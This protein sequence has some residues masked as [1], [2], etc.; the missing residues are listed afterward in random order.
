ME[1]LMR[2]SWQ[3]E[4][5]R[6]RSSLAFRGVSDA[7]HDLKTSLMRLGAPYP[8]LE[9]HLI[10]NFQKYGTLGDVGLDYSEWKWL[11]IGQHHRLPTRLLD[12]TY[13]PLVALHFA[14]ADRAKCER[15]G[16]VWCVDYVRSHKHIPALLRDA[17]EEVGAYTFTVGMLEDLV[18]S[19][20]RFDALSGEPFAIFFEPPSVDARIINQYAMFSVLSSPSETLDGWLAQ[21]PELYRRV[22]IPAR[23]K[24][25]VRDK[26]DQANV[27]ERVLFPGLDGL[28]AWLQRHYGPPYT[29]SAADEEPNE[30]TPPLRG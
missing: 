17:L 23:I 21:R 20:D 30:G 3:P 24:G 13:S 28:A 25:E 5:G 16:V 1:L 9:G 22:R 15:D 10:R 26:L 4:L 27:T 14:T 29:V 7:E 11:T 2:D 18:G 19:L 6:F 8:Q 12:W